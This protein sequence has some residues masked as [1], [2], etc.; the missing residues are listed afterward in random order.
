MNAIFFFAVQVRSAGSPLIANPTLYLIRLAPTL[1]L[2]VFDRDMAATCWDAVLSAAV[3][4]GLGDVQRVDMG[5]VRS[6]DFE[7]PADVQ[8]HLDSAESIAAES[9]QR[10]RSA[11]ARS[12]RLLRGSP[13]AAEL[14]AEL[15]SWLVEGGRMQARLEDALKECMDAVN[16]SAAREEGVRADGRACHRAFELHL[17]QGSRE[18]R[19]AARRQLDAAREL[20][21]AECAWG[22]E[23]QRMA[24]QHAAELQRCESEVAQAR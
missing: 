2:D 22:D 13:G 4:D 21:S 17:A 24:R 10:L 16:A 19:E 14:T 12:V 1:D 3:Q 9:K 7:R 18:S 6:D 23:K 11:V 15:E 20:E 8:V 5:D